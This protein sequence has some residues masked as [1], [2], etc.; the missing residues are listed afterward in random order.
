MFS[1]RRASVAPVD[2]SVNA[3]PVSEI[4]QLKEHNRAL[5]ARVMALEK[6][7]SELKGQITILTVRLHVEEERVSE[8]SAGVTFARIQKPSEVS[9]LQFE[10]ATLRESNSR[11]NR[12]MTKLKKV[13]KESKTSADEQIASLK[14]ENTTLIRQMAEVNKTARTQNTKIQALTSKVSELSE[15]N[16]S[17]QAEMEDCQRTILRNRQSETRRMEESSRQ[18][19]KIQELT[20]KVSELSQANS[21]LETVVAQDRRATASSQEESNADKQTTKEKRLIEEIEKCLQ[22]PLTLELFVNPNTTDLGHTFEEKAILTWLQN[23]DTCPLTRGFVDE[24]IPS[25][26]IKDICDLVRDFRAGK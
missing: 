21:Q 3:E 13:F 7:E 10:A 18:H 4:S 17:L 1:R 19:A 15:A 22:C 24:L 11:L 12:A 2:Q 26:T 23:H 25:K 8:L 5:I 9:R 14:S 20:L 6:Y 16:E